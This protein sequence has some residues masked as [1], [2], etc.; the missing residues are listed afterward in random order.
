MIAVEQQ[1]HGYR[2]GHQLL[3]STTKLDKADQ[4]LVNRLSDVAGSL[5][6]GETF[7]PYL[8]AYSIPSERYYVIARTWQDLDVPRAGCV[9]TLSLLISME[10]WGAAGSIAGFLALLNLERPPVSVART[11][12]ELG[13]AEYLPQ[14]TEF[15]SMELLEAL[16]FEER[17]PIVVFDALDP[18]LIAARLLTSLWPSFRRKFA[19][20]TFALSPRTISGRSFDLV[21]APKEVRARFSDWDGRR[22]D[23]RSASDLGR[24][25]WSGLIAERV[26]LAPVPHL[27]SDEEVE[28]FESDDGASEATLRIALL[29][30]ELQ[31]KLEF[32]P[33]AALGLLD[34]ANTRSKR[35]IVAIRDLEPGLVHATTRAAA[36]MPAEDAWSFLL[37]MTRK[38][39]SIRIGLST[40]RS[41]R[42]TAIELTTRWPAQALN[43]VVQS[44]GKIAAILL[45]A[46]AE[47]FARG[48]K[49][50]I[51]QLLTEAPPEILVRLLTSSPALAEAAISNDDGVSAALAGALTGLQPQLFAEAKRK[52][53]RLLVDERHAVAA[54]PFI[55]SLG[56]DE[57]S[58]ELSYLYGVNK[59]ASAAILNSLVARALDVGAES[60]ILDKAQAFGPEQSVENL[61]FALL[62]PRIADIEWVLN[63]ALPDVR[64]TSLLVRFLSSLAPANLDGIF[65]NN[66]ESLDRVVQALPIDARDVNIRIANNVS[67]PLPM[68]VSVVSRILVNDDLRSA[69][70]LLQRVLEKCLSEAFG[71]DEIA[72]VVKVLNRTDLASIGATIV[73]VG[74]DRRVPCQ[75]VSRN[76]LAF[77][78]ASDDARTAIVGQ[79]EILARS[80][81]DR[82][83]FDLS[84]QAA[85]ACSDLLWDARLVAPQ[86]M[87]R[88]SHI[89]LP[90]LLR[91][92][93]EPA[94]PL[95][96]AVF[97]AVY[98]HL[99]KQS[100]APDILGFWG[101]VE[102]DRCKVARRE[103]V[104][105]FLLSDWR[106]VDLAL[107]GA[108]A[109]DLPRIFEW[110]VRQDRGEA[111]LRSIERDVGSIGEPWQSEVRT[112]IG[113][114]RVASRKPK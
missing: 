101:L 11:A 61:L 109:G 68:L 58:A 17:K 57:L 106:P 64:R 86:A 91:A 13:L 111:Y 76:I 87:L 26:F 29:W 3:A 98:S 79:S 92:R 69:Q 14:V 105:A 10:D 5:R 23:A 71:G 4:E 47:G 30:E 55:A 59:L 38:L 113:G 73:R 84:V 21:F 24:H 22:I 46:V 37:A 108:R 48:H 1:L 41:I 75:V 54:I 66:Y 114:L 53:F 6:P 18:E 50:E 2:Q 56:A 60:T 20:S 27:L 49:R 96:A 95:V 9:R 31:A 102:W 93:R 39:K 107:A 32:S 78:R 100:D 51:A 8:T 112:A 40:A 7:K 85:E 33:T 70:P 103:L 99:K 81:V 43:V 88:A 110:L 44:D 89:L 77:N 74:F 63:C 97:P 15:R 25:H 36:T 82:R 62:K 80:L 72:F 83:T 94:S 104:S 12:V 45:S 35:D 65:A 28:F 16:F 52:L 34:I 90:F 19:V 67:M 42:A